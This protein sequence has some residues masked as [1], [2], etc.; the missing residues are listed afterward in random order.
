MDLF[1]MLPSEFFNPL[2]SNANNRI[3]AACL[4]EIYRYF[5]E[6]M[7]FRVEQDELITFLSDCL[8]SNHLVLSGEESEEKPDYR[9]MAR[10]VVR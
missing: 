4:I 5:D 1:N 9:A 2:A 10:S 8:Y 6:S 3:Y 7:D